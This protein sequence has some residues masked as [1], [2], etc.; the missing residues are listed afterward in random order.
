MYKF[1][2]FSLFF[3]AVVWGTTNFNF[4]VQTWLHKDEYITLH[5][6]TWSLLPCYIWWS[7]GATCWTDIA[8][9]SPI[10]L[11]QLPRKCWRSARK[12]PVRTAWL[13][14]GTNPTSPTEWSWST[15]SNTMKRYWSDRGICTPG[16]LWK[17]TRTIK[18]LQLFV[19]GYVNIF[20][21]FSEN[22]SYKNHSGTY[23][24]KR[25]DTISALS[26]EHK[27]IVFKGLWLKLGQ[28]FFAFRGVA[29]G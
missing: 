3:C 23:E 26:G 4:V 7:W 15:T 24:R 14:C 1:A 28:G 25:S 18:I 29:V 19:L 2:L 13:C 9:I 22:N 5:L 21:L 27:L 17:K 16:K 6:I 11:M 20:F 8:V 12:T 10:S